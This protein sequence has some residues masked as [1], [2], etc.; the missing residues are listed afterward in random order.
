MD[1][2]PYQHLVDLMPEVVFGHRGTG[3]R[4]VRVYVP[5]EVSG[6][7]LTQF[8]ARAEKRVEDVKKMAE[9]YQF[10]HG[11]FVSIPDYNMEKDEFKYLCK[12]IFSVERQMVDSPISNVSTFGAGADDDLKMNGITYR[13]AVEY[14]LSP[15]INSSATGLH[16]ALDAS[17]D[18][19]GYGWT[20]RLR[21]T[22][23]GCVL[24]YSGAALMALAAGHVMLAAE[25]ELQ[26]AL[27]S[28]RRIR[29]RFEE[30]GRL[31]EKL[32]SKASGMV[33]VRAE[34]ACPWE[35]APVEILRRS[36]ATPPRAA[37]NAPDAGYWLAAMRHD[38]AA[39]AAAMLLYAYWS[40]STIWQWLW[41]S[42]DDCETRPNVHDVLNDI[43]QSNFERIDEKIAWEARRGISTGAVFVD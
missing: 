37:G 28:L 39:K 19:K 25:H 22:A 6:D 36:E 32:E 7:D 18:E 42:C 8:D 14:G 33:G 17:R 11:I 3:E 4:N 34:S 13:L 31:A 27:F 35:L 5:D 1:E 20:Y 29:D 24:N 12:S 40:R 43:I 15:D 21:R 38:R 16:F 9:G 2:N 23:E 41:N 26:R 10:L 30:L